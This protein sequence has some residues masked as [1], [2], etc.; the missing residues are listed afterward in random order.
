MSNEAESTY[1]LGMKEFRSGNVHEALQLWYHAS[2]LGSPDAS[3]RNSR[4]LKL[5]AQ[6][7]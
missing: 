6:S 4:R 5:L 1:K 2:E 3:R 7:S